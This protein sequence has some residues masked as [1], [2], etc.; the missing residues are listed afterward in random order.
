MKI[1]GF[2]AACLVSLLLAACAAAQADNT[3]EDISS[4]I[5]N[6]YPRHKHPG[7]F[8]SPLG[9]LVDEL[10]YSL[11]PSPPPENAF[12][13]VRPYDHIPLHAQQAV[14]E[15]AKCPPQSSFVRMHKA[16][17]CVHRENQWFA[18]CVN[19]Q[20]LDTRYRNKRVW[21]VHAF[22]RRHG[23]IWLETYPQ[24]QPQA[25]RCTIKVNAPPPA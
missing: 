19:N 21:V 14:L 7:V 13:W 24:D 22:K 2:F 17:F 20:W 18:E 10:T 6:P 11:P 1:S 25:K 9:P 16:V 15:I 12:D 23:K 5:R 4:F 3:A 8:A